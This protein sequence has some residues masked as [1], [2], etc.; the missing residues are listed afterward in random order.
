ML[1]IS[2]GKIY[3]F[4]LLISSDLWRNRNFFEILT[5]SWSF[6][7]RH[8]SFESSEIAFVGRD[9]IPPSLRLSPTDGGISILPY[10]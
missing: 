6:V 7:I 1:G 10:G 3:F 9:E 5:G 8:S 4:K 2:K